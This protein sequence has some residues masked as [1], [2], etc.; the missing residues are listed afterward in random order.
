M[1]IIMY[2]FSQRRLHKGSSI[3]D[4]HKKIPFLTPLS[5]C[6]HMGLDAWAGPPPP[7]VDVHTRS[8]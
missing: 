8:T 5:T 4:V 1:H 3:Y 2:L 6:V 7:H